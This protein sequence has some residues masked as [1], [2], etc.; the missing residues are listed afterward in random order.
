MNLKCGFVLILQPTSLWGGGSTPF[1][2]DP[3]GQTNLQTPTDPFSGADPFGE[4]P[5]KTGTGGNG[6]DSTTGGGN[7]FS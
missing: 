7:P 3:F 5:F 4:D 1:D 2:V 6:S